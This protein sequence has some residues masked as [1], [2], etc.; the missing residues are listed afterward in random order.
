MRYCK[1]GEDWSC[2]SIW[3]LPCRAA[4]SF[5]R[6]CE[7]VQV[8]SSPGVQQCPASFELCCYGLRVPRV[9]TCAEVPPNG[10]P[11]VSLRLT[12]PGSVES[13]CLTVSYSGCPY[14]VHMM[15]PLGSLWASCQLTGSLMASGRLSVSVRMSQAACSRCS[16]CSRCSCSTASGHPKSHAMW[17][18]RG[19]SLKRDW[20]DWLKKQVNHVP[21]K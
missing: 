11:L 17:L 8:G 15:L 12:N 13:Q 19:A 20:W 14:D 6:P 1:H 5:C 21:E 16:R 7:S 10:S 3:H 9:P 18:K 2:A 4:R